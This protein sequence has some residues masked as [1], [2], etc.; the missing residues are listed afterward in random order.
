MISGW[1]GSKKQAIQEAELDSYYSCLAQIKEVAVPQ[2]EHLIGDTFNKIEDTYFRFSARAR[3]NNE[4]NMYFEAFQE[5]RSQRD[6]II[7]LF[8]GE[9][10]KGFDRSTKPKALLKEHR[11]LEAMVATENLT[12][13]DNDD[14][15]ENI[16]I[17][18]MVSLARSRF[19]GELYDLNER[20]SSLCEKDVVDG[21]SNPLDPAQI[22][23][24]FLLASVKLRTEIKTKLLLYKHFDINLLRNMSP[25]LNSA[26]DLL[27]DAGVLPSLKRFVVLDPYKSSS[28]DVS[29]QENN[30]KQ[31]GTFG[32]G[33][34]SGQ[35]SG[36]GQTGSSGQSSGSGRQVRHGA[37]GDEGGRSAD[38]ESG[39]ARSS[40]SEASGSGDGS[41]RREGYRGRRQEDN[42]EVFGVLRSLLTDTRESKDIGKKSADAINVSQQ[43]LMS[44]LS[45]MQSDQ[46][47]NIVLIKQPKPSVEGVE[48]FDSAQNPFYIRDALI[49]NLQDESK[50]EARVLGQLD[51]DVINLV[52]MLFEFI[53]D[54]YNLPAAMQVLIGRLQIPM[55]K[56]A[57]QDRDFFNR[58]GHPA[59][60]LL[61]ELAR[62][63]IGWQ[64]SVGGVKDELFERMSSV[65][66]AVLQDFSGD[67][68]LFQNLYD[69]FKT[70]VERENRRSIIIERRTKELALG[71]S[72]SRQARSLVGHILAEKSQDKG[73]LP[74]VAKILN[75]G[76][77]KVLFRISLKEGADSA[78]W[79]EAIQVVD[80]LIWSVQ[81]HR[82]LESQQ[83]RAKMLPSL[84]QRLHQGLTK[85]SFNPFEMS[86][87]FSEL[88]KVH[89]SVFKA[90]MEAGMDDGAESARKVSKPFKSDLGGVEVNFADND[91]I[92]S[93]VRY[94]RPEAERA[95][96]DL[97]RGHKDQSILDSLEESGIGAPVQL[98][99][100]LSESILPEPVH[101]EK[102]ESVN[103]EAHVAPAPES[104]GADDTTFS[105]STAIAVGRSWEEMSAVEKQQAHATALMATRL[106][107][108]D[109]LEVGGWFEITRED[110][111]LLRCKLIEKYEGAEFVFVGRFGNK[112]AEKNR[113]ELADDF[114][115]KR[116]VILDGAPL[117]DRS[118]NRLMSSLRSKVTVEES[119]E[120]QRTE[121]RIEKVACDD[122]LGDKSVLDQT[123]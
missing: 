24:A 20:L 41:A 31:T 8:M 49:E 120:K 51:E 122:V 54:D 15:E 115:N 106:S 11:T 38:Y 33:H 19:Q 30:A 58:P 91:A 109:D 68:A 86:S 26:N 76:W 74:I 44:V 117:V 7:S 102:L 18:G 103:V 80:D 46:L 112:V 107:Q 78:Q 43:D 23:E 96:R 6:E 83:L 69:E 40:E 34:S 118:I 22:C 4:Q 108:V 13:L 3:S 53:L 65:V 123:V 72:K 2:F 79:N 29:N 57:I 104:N 89:I 88:E 101:S 113:F 25:I 70:F 45:G 66:Q 17:E 60:K 12:L 21:S 121:P 100:N 71:E 98:D 64:E 59:R 75:D 81:V 62:A 50:D 61:N 1:D 5:I 36:S 14:L 67:I 94:A 116:I 119:P 99:V 105:S 92:E 9:L 85:A 77:S 111:S 56:V 87:L 110:G 63:S 55:L 73:L 47:K 32:L 84:L 52:A 37:V 48:S 97:Q 35:S 27:I 16:A 90:E 10:G 82:S 93:I 39:A 95:L 42:E 28:G 114:L